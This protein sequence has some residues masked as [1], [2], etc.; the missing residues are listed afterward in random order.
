MY[1]LQ[2]LLQYAVDHNM[3]DMD[4]VTVLHNYKAYMSDYFN[5]LA[6]DDEIERQA[7][8]DFYANAV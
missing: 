2:D 1:D 7:E 4:F 5:S 8:E 3:M 6:A